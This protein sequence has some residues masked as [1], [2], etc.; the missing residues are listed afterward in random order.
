MKFKIGFTAEKETEKKAP[1]AETKAPEEAPARESL[2]RVYFPQRGFDCTYYNNLFDLHVGDLVYVDG[3]LEGKRGKV[4]DV[5]YTFKIKLS[6][7]KRV[8]AKIDTDISGEFC[9]VGDVL[10]SFDKITVP[11]G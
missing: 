4:I 11:C 10:F 7:Y 6:D 9:Y 1:E 5:S 2:V 8:I 3:K